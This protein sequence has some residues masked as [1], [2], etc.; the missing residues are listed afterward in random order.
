[1]SYTSLLID[2]CT[3]E[4]YTEGAQNTYG[5]PA[6]TWATHLADEACRLVDNGGVEI[7]IGQEVVI[8]DHTLFLDDVD[9]TEQDRVIISSTTY[10]ILLVKH[11]SDGFGKHHVEAM[12]RT[13]R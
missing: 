7:Q 13:V 9:I 8:S 1:M 11:P 10:Q 2:T 6:K 3:V 12:L 5:H 4:R